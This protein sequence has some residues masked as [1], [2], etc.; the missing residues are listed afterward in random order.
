MMTFGTL[1][2]AFS[3]I[4]SFPLFYSIDESIDEHAKWS[5]GKTALCAFAANAM[6]LLLYDL[7]AQV[8][9]HL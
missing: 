1:I 5:V 2:Y 9:G 8:I 6:A 3:F 4:T 7:A